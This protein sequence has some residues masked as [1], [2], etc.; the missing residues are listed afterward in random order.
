VKKLIVSCVTVLLVLTAFGV[1]GA[2]PPETWESPVEANFERLYPGFVAGVP[3]DSVF[4]EAPRLLV[5]RKDG[6]QA[7]GDI[8][9]RVV[10]FTNLLKNEPVGE[11]VKGKEELRLCAPFVELTQA[12][13]MNYHIAEIID[14]TGET[15]YIPVYVYTATVS[16]ESAYVCCVEI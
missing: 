14:W 5:L 1:A 2:M 10:R 12:I 16:G 8:Y 4:A 3:E 15:L 6:T 9:G 11:I 7:M 13:T